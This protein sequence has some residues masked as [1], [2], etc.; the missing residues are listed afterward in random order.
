MLF[1]KLSIPLLEDLAKTNVLLSPP[2]SMV[3]DITKISAIPILL[4]KWIEEWIGKSIGFVFQ[5]SITCVLQKLN[6]PSEVLVFL[7]NKV[8]AVLLKSKQ[9]AWA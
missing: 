8:E 9:K 3:L 6:L 7:T 5:V 2:N 4:T 1:G